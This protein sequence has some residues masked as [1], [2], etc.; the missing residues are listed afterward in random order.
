MLV[1]GAAIQL[2]PK[3]YKNENIIVTMC[4]FVALCSICDR[5]VV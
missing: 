3:K 4:G 2:F 5:K 1:H